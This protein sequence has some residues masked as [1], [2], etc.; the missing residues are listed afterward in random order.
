M[1]QLGHKVIQ[2][3][4][5]KGNHQGGKADGFD[6][7]QDGQL[8]ACRLCQGCHENDQGHDSHV[9]QEED[10]ES[11]TTETAV[12]LTSIDKNAHD[13]GGTGEGDDGAD[14]QGGSIANTK[15]DA[16]DI[17]GGH[18]EDDLQQPDIERLGAESAETAEGEFQADGKKQQGRADFSDHI[19][20]A[21]GV[22]PTEHIRS[23][24]HSGND[25]SD[26]GALLKLLGDDAQDQGGTEQNDDVQ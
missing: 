3:D 20:F 21:A 16:G 14:G 5:E 1:E 15:R 9:L 23:A 6:C 22:D 13:T 4:V 18:G 2:Y 12:E 8:G 7:R 25:I 26:D 11:A 17:C 19:D 24:D 10:T